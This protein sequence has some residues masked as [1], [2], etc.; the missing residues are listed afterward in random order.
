MNEIILFLEN[1]EFNWD[2]IEIIAVTFSIIYVI[3]A[4]KE[5]IWCWSAAIISVSLYIYIC[6]INHLYAETILQVFYLIIA[7]YGY[8]NWNN[9]RKKLHVSE[10][11]ISKHIITIIIGTTIAFLL[12]FY[13]TI[14]TN[15]AMPIIDSFTTTFSII[16]T[17]MVTKKILGNWLYWIIIDLTSIYMYYE[18]DLHLTSML[19]I[20]YTII[21]VFGYMSWSRLKR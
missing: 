9:P 14:Y 18:K 12:G 10:W 13:L 7:F 4:A 15:A 19:F 17:F 1:I 21:A 11:N 2:I 5:N 3:L 20:I 16:A 8:Y 6:F